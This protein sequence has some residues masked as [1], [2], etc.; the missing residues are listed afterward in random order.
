[1]QYI[2]NAASEI[3]RSRRFLQKKKAWAFLIFPFSITARWQT[4]V[5]QASCSNSTL[6]SRKNRGKGYFTF[7]LL[8]RS[9]KHRVEKKHL[10]N[11]G[12]EK[13]WKIVQFRKIGN[14]P[15]QIQ[16]KQWTIGNP[17]TNL[18]KHG[19][20]RELPHSDVQKTGGKGNKSRQNKKKGQLSI[21]NQGDREP[22]YKSRKTGKNRIFFHTESGE[23]RNPQIHLGKTGKKGQLFYTES[24]GKGTHIKIQ[25]KQGKKDNFSIQ[26]QGKKGTLIQIQ[27]KHGKRATFLYRIMGEREPT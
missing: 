17:H 15:I 24:R 3:R 18:T 25:T 5:E 10:Y 2:G 11:I 20:I 14:F 6:G 4:L 26:N 13:P 7:T 21:Q 16:R 12:L 9:W 27:A 22:P 1:M 19:K 23:K 8:Y